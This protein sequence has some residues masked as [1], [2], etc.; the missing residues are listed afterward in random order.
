MGQSTT[1]EKEIIIDFHPP[2]GFTG[3]WDNGLPTE[4]HYLNGKRHRLDG[5]AY[6]CEAGY[7]HWVDGEFCWPSEYEQKVAEYKQKNGI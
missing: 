3:I 1:E 6:V 4:E 7:S 2:D 5:P